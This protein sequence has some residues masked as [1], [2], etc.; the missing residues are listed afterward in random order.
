MCSSLTSSR[1]IVCEILISICYY[2][3]PQGQKLI[4]EALKNLAKQS[5]IYSINPFEAWLKSWRQTIQLKNLHPAEECEYSVRLL[6]Y[7]TCNAVLTFSSFS[8]TILCLPMQL[9]MYAITVIH[10]IL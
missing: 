8:Y 3:Y 4:L 1:K 9:S 2:K 6:K 10:E 5:N 7:K